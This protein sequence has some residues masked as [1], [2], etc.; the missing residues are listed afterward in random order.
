MQIGFII[1]WLVHSLLLFIID[2]GWI[3]GPCLVEGEDAEL[4]EAK[5]GDIRHAV[6][7]PCNHYSFN[8]PFHKGSFLLPP[9]QRDIKSV[10]EGLIRVYGRN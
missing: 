5:S 8:V 2:D 6:H 4:N 10:L 1:N 7:P 3:L 9:S